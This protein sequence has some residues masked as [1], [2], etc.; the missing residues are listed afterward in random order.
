LW[1]SYSKPNGDSYSYFYSYSYAN[2]YG[3]SNDNPNSNPN[4]DS[5]AY[6]YPEVSSHSERASNSQ[7]ETVARRSKDSFISGFYS[8]L[9]PQ[10]LAVSTCLWFG[11]PLNSVKT[12][13]VILD[14]LTVSD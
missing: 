7:A 12:S 14:K 5:K 2:T 13:R 8:A 9:E 3:D 6:S 4:S 10:I 1:Q 11:R